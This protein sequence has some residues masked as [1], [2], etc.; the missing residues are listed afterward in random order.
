MHVLQ[1]AP[2]TGASADEP[3]SP[4]GSRYH[5]ADGDAAS[6]LCGFSVSQFDAQPIAWDDLHRVFQQC[7]G[8]RME[9]ESRDRT[10]RG[11][12]SPPEVALLDEFAHAHDNVSVHGDLDATH[13]GL[14]RLRL[15]TTT[16][17]TDG[18]STVIEGSGFDV[19]SAVVEL[20]SA[21]AAASS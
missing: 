8:C 9:L 4:F 21:Y 13:P 20:R 17:G 12:L 5:L 16:M 6:T 14:V 7:P 3:V 19:V 15:W 2:G 1:E 10:L 11:R 18:T